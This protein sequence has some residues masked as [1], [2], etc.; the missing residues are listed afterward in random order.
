MTG[1]PQGLA[2]KFSSVIHTVPPFRSDPLWRP[3][4]RSCYLAAVD[5]AIARGVEAI[6]CPV[7]GAG[8]RGAPMHEAVAV[9]VQALA[10]AGP[11]PDAGDGEA[12]PEAGRRRARGPASPRS[13]CATRTSPAENDPQKQTQQ[14]QVSLLTVHV[15][16]LDLRAEDLFHATLA[17]TDGWVRC[18]AS[19]IECGV[20]DGHCVL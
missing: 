4:L 16:L 7:L 9:A 8:A 13:S 14:Q 17:S 2:H 6:V 1:A 5:L 10:D 18:D 12:D 3:K 19:V 20:C 15:S 11:G